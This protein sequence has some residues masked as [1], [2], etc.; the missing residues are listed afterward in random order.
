VTALTG[1]WLIA[2]L[3]TGGVILR[4]WRLPEAIWAVAGAALLVVVG[5]LPAAAA[6]RGI[7][8][9]TDVYLFLT[10]MMLLAEVAR[11]EGLFDWMA[12]QAASFA[13]GSASRLFTLVYLVGMIV[14][15]FLSNDATAVVLT[16]AVAAVAH[17]TRGAAAALF[18]GLR[19]HRQCGVLRPAD[20]QSGQSGD[21]WQSHATAVPMAA[22]LYP[23]VASIDC[24]HLCRA[25][26]DAAIR[27]AQNHRGRCRNSNAFRLWPNCSRRHCIDGGGSNLTVSF[28]SSH[29]I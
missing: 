11:R 24:G 22:A 4:P 14:T 28:F 10:G 23:A 7:A 3:A 16:P 19:I 8:K 13:R 5:L 29:L 9:D 25:P 27:T 18:T 2:A 26:P 12:A 20:Q 15:V 21:L 1:T 17:R 6:W